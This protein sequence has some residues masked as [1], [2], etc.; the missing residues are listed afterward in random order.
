MLNF[1]GDILN[2]MAAGV[3]FPLMLAPLAVFISGG[4]RPL[5]AWIVLAAVITGAGVLFAWLT[6]I[7]SVTP[8]SMTAMT[9]A[10]ILAGLALLMSVSGG[11]QKYVDGL[12]PV[13][14]H[15]TRIAA[16]LVMWLL[17]AMALVQFGV[18]VLRY[19]FGINYIF[20]QE[21][22]TYMHGAVFLVAGGYALLTDDHVRVD[23]FYGQASPKRKALIDLLGTYL[24]L[25]PVCLLLL[26]AASPYVAN[27]WA[28]QE[29]STET[30][31]IQA[32]FLMKSLIPL[33][34]ML[35][36]MAGFTVAAKAGAVLKDRS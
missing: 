10:A 34:A 12:A 32:V 23:I 28:V 15:I 21:S 16:R 29:G 1:V 8:T 31:G 5:I 30:S 19:V 3:V 26:W 13:F 27:S 7:L 2:W 25:F 22:I 11:V 6:P 24:L 20:M 17:L 36:A 33:F 35:L 14:E 4:N 18:V 9:F